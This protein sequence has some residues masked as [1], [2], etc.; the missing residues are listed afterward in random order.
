[1]LVFTKINKD[2]F[3][4]KVAIHSVSEVNQNGD[5]TSWVKYPEAGTRVNR[6]M[7]VAEK[8]GHIMK[9]IHNANK[10]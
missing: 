7:R 9:K 8:F 3:K 4:S 10:G 6:N 5:G 2:G 1:M